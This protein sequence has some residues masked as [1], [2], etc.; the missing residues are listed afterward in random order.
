VD[1]IQLAASLWQSIEDPYALAAEL[2]DED[3]IALAL[4]RDAQ[5]ESGEVASIS[6]SDLMLRLR[7]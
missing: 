2:S 5:I 6:N 3:A 7:K 4:A 1:W